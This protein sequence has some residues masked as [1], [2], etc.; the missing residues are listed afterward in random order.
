MVSR[1]KVGNS[2]H[3]PT[4]LHIL[5]DEAEKGN[6]AHIVSWSAQGRSFKIHDQDALVPLLAKYFRQTKFKSFLR[7]L[8][9]YGFH[10]TTRGIDK[11]LVSHPYF[12]RGRRSLCFRMTRKLAGGA[13]AASPGAIAR[14]SGIGHSH[15]M[16][17]MQSMMYEIASVPSNSIEPLRKTYSAPMF[18]TSFS[19]FKTSLKSGIEPC[20]ETRSVP[21]ILDDNASWNRRFTEI[22]EMKNEP[23]GYQGNIT[24][25]KNYNLVDPVTS[26][27]GAF[28]ASSAPEKKML[29]PA[30]RTSESA[31]N[32]SSAQRDRI[33]QC[34][35]I[36]YRFEPS[37]I[38]NTRVSVPQ[39][40]ILLSIR[41]SSPT[42][43]EVSSQQQ[44]LFQVQPRQHQELLPKGV[45]PQG[46]A[47]V[48]QVQLTNV[49][50]NHVH[51]KH[52][53]HQEHEPRHQV[54]LQ[55]Q[56]QPEPFKTIQ[57]NWEQQHQIGLQPTPS[58]ITEA[59]QVYSHQQV[60]EKLE[61]ARQEMAKHFRDQYNLKEQNRLYYT[62]N[63]PNDPQH[64]QHQ[65]VEFHGRPNQHIVEQP[66]PQQ[67]ECTQS[68]QEQPHFLQQND[69]MYPPT[70]VQ[71]HQV[72]TNRVDP[73]SLDFVATPRSGTGVSERSSDQ[74]ANPKHHNGVDHFAGLSE[75]FKLSFSSS[76]YNHGTDG[77]EGT[78]VF[79]S[80]GAPTAHVSSHHA[81]ATDN[82]ASFSVAISTQNL[83]ELP[84]MYGLS[85][86]KSTMP[87]PRCD[88]SGAHKMKIQPITIE[89]APET[90][91]RTHTE[92]SGSFSQQQQQYD[93][94]PVPIRPV[95]V[96]QSDCHQS[97]SSA[98]TCNVSDEGTV[99]F[100]L[101]H[102]SG[103][104]DE[105]DDTPEMKAEDVME[106]L[107]YYG[108]LNSIDNADPRLSDSQV[109]C[110]NHSSNPVPV[111]SSHVSSSP[112]RQ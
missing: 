7:Q 67:P 9:S 18:K 27:T 2:Q 94:S 12:V 89:L 86:T 15:R 11:G 6:H 14:H 48:Q 65:Q 102:G 62:S 100:L 92:A 4:N 106:G 36:D 35:E 59:E 101:Q 53:Y 56:A 104:C 46:Q 87:L 83:G 10:R 103:G 74:P 30:R 41:E 61:Q 29:P 50:Q 90:H 60:V 20:G 79:H 42:T 78:R 77:K 33:L 34:A 66:T 75:K 3:F 38:N 22:S 55:Y 23:F 71:Y 81:T 58:G 95:S 13:N 72:Q 26:S 32:V 97:S 105:W 69:K 76:E 98:K 45:L 96:Q 19:S 43:K 16:P 51:P 93:V 8:Q 73:Q 57:Y 70:H 31:I 17:S 88:T 82:N 24:K 85:T 112:D 64:C 49:P 1:V 39:E 47:Q 54:H 99:D 110:S 111:F 28:Y 5:L 40:S 52:E 80:S 84:S 21:A 109:H 37:P 91:Q 25:M 63:A 108:F 68:Y 44:V 107:N